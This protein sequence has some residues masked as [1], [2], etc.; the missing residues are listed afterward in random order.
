LNEITV[1]EE[2]AKMNELTSS[3]T[4]SLG[5]QAR[6]PDMSPVDSLEGTEVWEYNSMAC[7]KMI[8]QLDKGLMK[9]Y[10]NQTDIYEGNTAVVEHEDKDQAAG[11][12]IAES[13]ILCGHQAYT[14]RALL[15]LF[16]MTV[17]WK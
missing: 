8:V 12:V 16:T 4:L 17:D 9:I 3:I 13:F 11:L 2:F 1:R 5:V 14:S 15:Y 10:T 7:P 6:V